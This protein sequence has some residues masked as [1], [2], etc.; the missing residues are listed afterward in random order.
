MD[1]ETVVSSTLKQKITLASCFMVP[2]LI[3]LLYVGI[4]SNRNSFENM[5]SSEKMYEI[6][7][8]ASSGGYDGTYEEWLNNISGKSVELDIRTFTDKNGDSY[9]ALLWRQVSYDLDG[10][11]T[12]EGDWESIYNLTSYYG[13]NAFELWKEVVKKPQIDI[14]FTYTEWEELD[15]S[16]FFN[17]MYSFESFTVAFEHDNK[18]ISTKVITD[19][20]IISEI[21]TVSLAEGYEFDG[22]YFGDVEW[23]LTGF[24]VKQNMTLVSKVSPIETSIEYVLNDGIN[25]ADNIETIN[26][27]ESFTL[28]NPTK[29]G[30]EFLGWYTEDNT[31]STQIKSL[32]ARKDHITL[33]AQWQPKT[34]EVTYVLYENTAITS[35]YVYDEASPNFLSNSDLTANYMSNGVYLDPTF[36]V[37]VTK[38]SNDLI[39][40]DKIILYVDTTLKIEKTSGFDSVTYL[41]KQWFILESSAGLTTLLCKDSAAEN[42]SF[43]GVYESLNSTFNDFD[44][45]NDNI[46]LLVPTTSLYGVSY[47]NLL[48]EYNTSLIGNRISGNIWLNSGNIFSTSNASIFSPESGV[49]YGIYP[50]ITIKL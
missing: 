29:E 40:N 41:G 27:D 38:L 35:Q 36:T 8:L 21:P 10:N 22:W 37:K 42:N 34:Y 45:N 26:Y 1:N 7:L 49:R 5:A 28:K 31:T 2:I 48:S 15:E 4:S 33:Y 11:I 24:V 14:D 32:G 6:Y 20:D 17:E 3:I 30:Y 25:N 18:V 12:D 9:L 50:V 47:V 46:N 19:G 16:D 44:F 13:Y 39:S 23:N 43:S